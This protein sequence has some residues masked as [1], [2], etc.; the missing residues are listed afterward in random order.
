[1]SYR[2]MSLNDTKSD[3]LVAFCSTIFINLR[4]ISFAFLNST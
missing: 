4:R 1:L 3:Q 2:G